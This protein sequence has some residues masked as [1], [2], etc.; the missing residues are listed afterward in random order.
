MIKDA[1]QKLINSHFAKRKYS[2]DTID[3]MMREHDGVKDGSALSK[4]IICAS[5]EYSMSRTRIR[6]ETM[7]SPEAM[8]KNPLHHPFTLVILH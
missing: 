8:L 7:C 1:R 3:F 2:F 5:L 4:L 6:L